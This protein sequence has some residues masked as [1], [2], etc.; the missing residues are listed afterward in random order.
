MS[1]IVKLN[2][3]KITRLQPGPINIFNILIVSSFAQGL[4]FPGNSVWRGH[5]QGPSELVCLGPGQAPEGY[6]KLRIN[7][8]GNYP[9]GLC[10]FKL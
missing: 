1:F 3:T 5:W 8:H 2:K 7:S 4:S 9:G 6:H 10:Q